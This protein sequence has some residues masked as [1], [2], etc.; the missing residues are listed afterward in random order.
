MT[1]EAD[2]LKDVPLFKL[3]D[4]RERTDLAAQLEVVSFSAG[5]TIFNYGDPGHAI[6]VVADGEVE[7]SF[8]NDT[9]RK[10]VV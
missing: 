1:P 5:D 9:D 8:K 3:L 6:F 7:I 10:S 4:E 2:L